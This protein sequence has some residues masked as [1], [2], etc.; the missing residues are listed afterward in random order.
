VSEN[1]FEVGSIP[2][3]RLTLI[4]PEYCG[5]GLRLMTKLSSLVDQTKLNSEMGVIK[6]AKKTIM[7][8]EGL[9]KLFLSSCKDND[10]LENVEL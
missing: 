2:A 3:G 8:D 5:F 6:K 4:R 10:H 9:L 1:K 7:E